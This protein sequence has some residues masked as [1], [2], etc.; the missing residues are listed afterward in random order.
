MIDGFS[1][2]NTLH[3]LDKFIVLLVNVQTDYIEWFYRLVVHDDTF[4]VPDPPVLLVHST[5]ILDM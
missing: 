2:Q 1:F 3:R 5:D 4:I